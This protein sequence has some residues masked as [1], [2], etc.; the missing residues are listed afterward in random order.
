MSE[1]VSEVS[2]GNFEK[3]VLQA[4]QPVLV[5][6]WAEWCGPCRM[7]APAVEAV[8]QQYSGSAV[9]VKLNVDESP[10]VAARYG[11]RGI[12]TLIL[13]KDGKEAERVVGAVPKDTI[14]RLI[15]KHV[16]GE[17]VS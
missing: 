15:D 5:D 17:V 16:G 3:D 11:V 9:V 12:P 6:F 1:Y 8:A 7:L 13:F 4:S 14:S 2:E 10:D